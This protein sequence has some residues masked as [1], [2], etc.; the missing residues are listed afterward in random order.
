MI[1][2]VFRLKQE[3]LVLVSL[4]KALYKRPS[5]LCGK[6]EVKSCSQSVVVAE[7][8]EHQFICMT[9]KERTV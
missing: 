2:I 6:Q 9:Q 5:V 7:Q 4:D 3:N 8:T 1:I